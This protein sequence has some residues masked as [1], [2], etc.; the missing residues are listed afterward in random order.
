[1]APDAATCITN[2]SYSP[3]LVRDVEPNDASPLK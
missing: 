3:R 2:A 1:M